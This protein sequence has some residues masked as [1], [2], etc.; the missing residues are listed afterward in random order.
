MQPRHCSYCRQAVTHSASRSGLL[1]HAQ[2]TDVRRNAL[3]GSLLT[4][5]SPAPAAP[6]QAKTTKKIVLRMQCNE[7]KQSCMKPLKVRRPSGQPLLPDSLP[8]SH[9]APGGWQL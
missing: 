7:C 5:L 1:L 9:G 3:V 4:P 8:G 6:P 2:F